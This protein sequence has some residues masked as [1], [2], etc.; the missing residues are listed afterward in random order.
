MPFSKNAAL[1]EEWVKDCLI[2]T[3]KPGDVVA[4]DNFSSRKG[5]RIEQ[6]IKAAGAEL[7]YCR[8]TAPT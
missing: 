3:L 6:M 5:A 7:R 8:P 4:M 1:F 2:P